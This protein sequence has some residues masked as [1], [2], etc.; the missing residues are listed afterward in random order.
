MHPF[1]DLIDPDA[2]RIGGTVDA[3]LDQAYPSMFARLR[4]DPHRHGFRFKRDPLDVLRVISRPHPMRPSIYYNR[5][6][7]KHGSAELLDQSRQLEAMAKLDRLQQAL[8]EAGH[9]ARKLPAYMLQVPTI[10]RRELDRRGLSGQRLLDE[11]D[12]EPSLPQL[13]RIGAKTHRHTVPVTK[14]TLTDAGT[15]PESGPSMLLRCYIDRIDVVMM[16]LA[17]GIV[18]EEDIAGHQ[19]RLT[20]CPLPA[21]AVNAMSAL[22]GTPVSQ[23]IAHPALTSEQLRIRYVRTYKTFTKIVI[24]GDRTRLEDVPSSLQPMMNQISRAMA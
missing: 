23:V 21:T 7:G 10:L 24:D 1:E 2:R 14:M 11:P 13:L 15:F 22:A 16:E 3:L 12:A 9:P 18:V 6:H 5:G 19:I 20:G 17:P 4:L 8:E